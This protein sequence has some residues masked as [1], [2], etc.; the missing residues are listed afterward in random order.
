MLAA[1]ALA[2]H[3]RMTWLYFR[4]D[5]AQ[6]SPILP[7]LGA[8]FFP[9]WAAHGG[10]VAAAALFFL[11]LDGLGRLC[12]PKREWPPFAAAGLGLLLWGTLGFLLAAA[13]L[14]SPA[15]LRPASLLLVA[16]GLGRGAARWRS[17]LSKP[18]RPSALEISLALFGVFYLLTTAV[19]ET[20][21]D[22]LVYHLTAPQAWLSAGRMTDMPDIHLWR[23]PGLMQPL[24]LWGLAWSD[25]RLC[26]LLNVGVAGLAAGHLGV[27][28]GRRWGRE[29]GGW[30][31]LLFLSSPMIGVNLWSCANDV[32]AAF[33][34]FLALTAWLEAW[35]KGGRAGFL[36]SGLFFGAA[37]A[38]KS[39]AFFAA[40]FFAADALRRARGRAALE[41]LL[42]FA[43]GALIPLLPWWVRTFSWTGNP[44]FPQGASFLGGDSPE[45]LALLRGWHAEMGSEEP[46][47]SR[48]LSLVRE[49]LRGVE[50][51]RFGFVGP[52]LL[53]GLPLAF[54]FRADA[55]AGVLG[56]YGLMAYIAFLCATGR[57]RYFLPH[58]SPLFA[59][60]AL[61]LVDYAK[62]TAG[63]RWGRRLGPAL[64][65]LAGVAVA[66]NL[67]WLAL[68]FQRFNQGWDVVWGRQD[69]SAYLRQEHIGVYGHPS[70]GA[71]DKLKEEPAPGRLFVI[72]EARTFRSPLPATA[73]ASFNVPPYAA[74]AGTPPSADRLLERLRATGHTHLLMNV[75][76]WK[77][78]TPADYKSDEQLKSL[79]ALLDR[80]SPPIYSD[81]WCLLFRLPPEDAR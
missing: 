22:A 66:L 25:D 71:F 54:F 38:M 4:P 56:G 29:V 35:E 53:M 65:A 10:R 19:P 40:P 12:A 6:L 36:W 33:F 58:L 45:N 11:S 49:S 42:F 18:F 63:D 52:A 77:R 1:Q 62:S 5:A 73:A 41:A 44:F 15:V 16:A 20:F 21:Y 9:L 47:F 64:K 76:E 80:L 74:W 27:W 30:A 55:A 17:A 69:A 31:A 57:L 7:R 28:A 59:L 81:R 39:T 68:V 23:L 46:L 26:K 79:G 24:Y 50:A 34:C 78:I 14:C 3:T 67:V 13:G 43:A 48:S 51:G 60:A 32:P 2:F 61:G 70:Q 37:A 8:S 75:E 72:G